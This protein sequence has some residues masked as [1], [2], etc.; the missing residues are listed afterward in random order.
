VTTTEADALAALA[1]RFPADFAW[2]AATAAYQ[3]EGSVRA[4]G[5]A[6]SI[7]DTFSHAPGRVIGG[8]T[9]D[10][11][12]N[13]YRRWR[14]DLELMAELGLR[15]YRFSVAW[16][17]V[18][19]IGHGPANPRGLDFYDR[20]VDGLL[21]R[22]IEPWVTL[23]HWDLPQTLEDAGGWTDRAI[24]D[25]F[26]DYA[27]LVAERLGDRVTRWIT[28]N[29]PRT[30][31]FMGY[32]TGRHAPGRRG[33]S[34]ALRAAHHSHLAHAAAVPVIRGAAPGARVG[35]CHDVNHA[36]AGS[37]RDDDRRAAARY[38]AALHDWFLGPTFGRGYP[39]G[40]VAWY[41]ERGLLDGI[42]PPAV[43]TAPGIDFLALN[44]YRRERIV[45][46]PPDEDWGVEAKA[47]PPLGERTA[48][49]W[50][51]DPDGL[52]AVL[53]AVHGRYAPPAIAITENGA[54]FD[55]V[56]GPDGR[57]DDEPRRE[58]L[59]R[60]IVAA[61]AAREAGVPLIGYFAWSLLDNF[62]WAMG[63]GTRFGIVRVDFATQQRTIKA[64]GEWYRALLAQRAG[65]GGTEPPR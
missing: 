56:V 32:G 64:S 18:Q 46:A 53:R 37:E 11:A 10:V 57:I 65:L 16:P 61:A 7:W 50:D 62:E 58:Y 42:D 13:H 21:E 8:D 27:G 15:A 28:L 43:E 52:E 33:W 39:A 26:V 40:I 45:A 4:D 51:V 1:A 25:R 5:R 29:E 49:G 20:L 34:T 63:Y 30:F 2:G 35:I 23:Y 19:P 6:P 9:G 59:E 44:Y 24:V 38:D 22:G 60:H 47:L 36:V 31:S 17:R 54:A 48:N 41:E 55:D 3:I 14:D 12:C